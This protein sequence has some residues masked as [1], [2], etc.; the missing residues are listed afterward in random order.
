MLLVG[1]SAQSESALYDIVLCA[2]EPARA[3]IENGETNVQN[4]RKASKRNGIAFAIVDNLVIIHAVVAAAR[5]DDLS[6]IACRRT[7]R[8][9]NTTGS[10]SML[11]RK[12]YSY[13][14]IT[15]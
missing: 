1:S 3:C 4:V 15:T 9:I 6:R 10:A 8:I 13:R 12:V 2:N 14:N 7:A 11:A 5:L